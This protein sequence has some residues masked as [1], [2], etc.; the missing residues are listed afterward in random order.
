MRRACEVWVRAVVQA[1][2][3]L[4]VQA[5]ADWVQS[6]E[7]EELRNHERVVVREEVWEARKSC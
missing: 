2:R 1:W 5:M 3:A 6:E 4:W 7:W